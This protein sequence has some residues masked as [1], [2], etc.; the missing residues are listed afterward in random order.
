M[1]RN[2]LSDLQLLEAG[3][4]RNQKAASAPS[5]NSNNLQEL[6]GCDLLPQSYEVLGMHG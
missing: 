3:N 1:W 2:K 6:Q 5:A 4:V